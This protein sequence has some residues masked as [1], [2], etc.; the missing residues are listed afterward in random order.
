MIS[1]MEEPD[2]TGNW[3]V[4]PWAATANSKPPQSDN[5]GLG[6]LPPV[7]AIARACYSPRQADVGS[8][9]HKTRG[10]LL[11]PRLFRENIWILTL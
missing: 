11:T 7:P 8:S 1:H 9:M 6:G 10:P 4:K 2:L 3:Q 5:R